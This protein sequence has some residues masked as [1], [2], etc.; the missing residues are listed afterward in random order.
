MTTLQREQVVIEADI[1]P[2]EE[3]ALVLANRVNGLLSSRSTRFMTPLIRAISILPFYEARDAARSAQRRRA[4]IHIIHDRFGSVMTRALPLW[5]RLN[6]R[7]IGEIR[8]T[9]VQLGDI[10]DQLEP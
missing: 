2:L 9:L 8:A 1:P 3:K 6:E 5:V 10:L 7:N 4:Q